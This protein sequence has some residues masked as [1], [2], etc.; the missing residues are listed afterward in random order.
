M[1]RVAHWGRCPLLRETFTPKVD[2]GSQA[3]YIG[4]SG[5]AYRD[6]SGHLYRLKAATLSKSDLAER[7]DEGFSFL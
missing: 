7:S 5:Q 2:E 4:E 1:P 6:E 3:A